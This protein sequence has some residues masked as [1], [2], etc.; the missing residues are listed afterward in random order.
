MKTDFMNNMTHEFNTPI[1]TIS[2]ATETIKNLIKNNQIEKVE[3]FAEI[4]KEENDRMN[5]QVNKV[6]LIAKMD[7]K[8]LDLHIE[9]IKIKD[10][11]LNAAENLSLQVEQKN[12]KIEVELC[13]PDP[14]IDADKTHITNVIYNLLDNAIKY[15]PDH[16]EIKIKLIEASGGIKIAVE[17]KGMGISNVARKYIFDKF[18]RI[19]TGD[20]HDIKGF[21]LGL[22]YVKAIVTAHAGSI[23]LKSELGKG[24]VFTVFFPF[25]FSG[26]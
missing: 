8:D 2:I 18:Y 11:I 7:K 25:K 26:K 20:V 1:A 15:S 6:L 17:D 16:P 12:G 13:D 19:P 22:S 24:S 9:K 3:R 4:I 21:G 14:E 23:E 5:S 10:I